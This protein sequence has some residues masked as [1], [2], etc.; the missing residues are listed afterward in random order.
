MTNLQLTLMPMPETVCCTR[1]GQCQADVLT[2][3]HLCEITFRGGGPAGEDQPMP[4]PGGFSHAAPLDNHHPARSADPRVRHRQ[5][6]HASAARIRRSFSG[7]ATI[8]SYAMTRPSF[9]VTP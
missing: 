1:C 2:E 3:R 5:R 6:H 7:L 9:T 4:A 8:R